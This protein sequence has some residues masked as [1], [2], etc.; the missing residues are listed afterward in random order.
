MNL[1]SAAAKRFLRCKCLNSSPYNV[2][3][4][5]RISTGDRRG[6]LYFQCRHKSSCAKFCGVGRN[7]LSK[8]GLSAA[9]QARIKADFGFVKEK[10]KPLPCCGGK[11]VKGLC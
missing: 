2:A 5:D 4:V 8:S 7:A 11:K 9:D 1:V 6:E 3:M 10:C